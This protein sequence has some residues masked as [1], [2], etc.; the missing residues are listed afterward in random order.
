MQ[1]EEAEDEKALRNV[2]LEGIDLTMEAGYTKPIASIAMS[3]REELKD[4]LM[5]H[6]TLY[7][8]KAVMD[9][10]KS[11]LCILGVGDANEVPQ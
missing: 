3:E 6:Y 2:C 8:N 10:L 1:I 9:Q 7:H 5:C 4:V 11:G